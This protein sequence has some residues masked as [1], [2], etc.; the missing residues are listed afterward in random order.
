METR[1]RGRV[2]KQGFRQEKTEEVSRVKTLAH[3]HTEVKSRCRAT[4][5]VLPWNQT[6]CWTWSAPHE[7]TAKQNQT[8]TSDSQENR[9]Q[10][11]L[12]STQVQRQEIWNNLRYSGKNC[13]K[14][15]PLAVL[16]FTDTRAACC[17]FSGSPWG[18][19]CLAAHAIH[20]SQHGQHKPP[21]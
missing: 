3:K 5:C 4:E 20:G 6:C 16:H 13:S 15:W 18:R 9:R 19:A 11:R 10:T 21:V 1:Q 14:P 8:P 2:W 17:W 12:G 7:R